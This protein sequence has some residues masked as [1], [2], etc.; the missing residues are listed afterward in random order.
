VQAK[1]T[2]GRQ[3]APHVAAVI[4][5]HAPATLQRRPKAASEPVVQPLGLGVIGSTLWSWGSSAASL[6]AANPMISIP[7][8]MAGVGYVAYNY[9]RGGRSLG[10]YGVEDLPKEE[11]WR[12]Y[13]NPKDFKEAEES[14]DPGRYYDNDKSPGFQKGMLRA[15]QEELFFGSNLGRKVDFKEYAR[16]HDM[17]SEGLTSGRMGESDTRETTRSLSSGENIWLSGGKAYPESQALK[18]KD[19]NFDI[20]LPVVNFPINDWNKSGTSLADDLA[21]ET[22]GGLPMVGKGELNSSVVRTTGGRIDVNYSFDQGPLITQKIFDRY[23]TEIS[24]AKSKAEKLRAI[25]K[26][27]RAVHVTHVFRDANGRLNVNILLNKFLVEQGFDPTVLPPEGLGMFGGGFSIDDLVN[28][29][30]KG[31]A[32]F[33]SLAEPKKNK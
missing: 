6:A 25:V 2:G 16:L 26:A 9:W 10:Q 30:E 12:M 18:M 5:S 14:K 13:I 11:L 28:A 29:V 19:T 1:A 8:A 20:M 7:M 17:V 23:Y 21:K 3:V 32:K 31:S 24:K 33:R 22:I 4:Q 27:V 15:L